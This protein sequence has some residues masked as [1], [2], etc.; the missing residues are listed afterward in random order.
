MSLLLPV[1]PWLTARVKMKALLETDDKPLTNTVLSWVA[2]QKIRKIN[3]L[4]FGCSPQ[5][6]KNHA[7]SFFV[8]N[9]KALLSSAF[10]LLSSVP[11]RMA[12]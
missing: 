1:F 9:L 5:R 3:S 2:E 6:R 4:I 8:S 11:A 7:F 12:K 10:F